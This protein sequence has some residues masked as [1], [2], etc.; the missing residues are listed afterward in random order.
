MFLSCCLFGELI[1]LSLV[2]LLELFDFLDVLHVAAFDFSKGSQDVSE[3]SFFFFIKGLVARLN[4]I[5]SLSCFGE[6][7]IG[8]K[9]LFFK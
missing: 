7:F 6:F 9:I 8:L 4:I 5:N 2:V 3:A 1:Q